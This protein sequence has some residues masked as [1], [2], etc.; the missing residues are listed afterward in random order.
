MS[1][2]S[3]ETL[4]LCIRQAVEYT[5]KSAGIPADTARHAGVSVS[6]KLN[7]LW[8]SNLIY[9]PRGRLHI[10]LRNKKIFELFSG[11]NH[12]QLAR[13]FNVSIQMIYQIVKKERLLYVRNQQ[14]DLF[15]T[16]YKVDKKQVTKYITAKLYV[17]AEIMEITAECLREI[18]DI[19][20]KR[21]MEL[22]EEVAKW[23]SL[24]MGGQSAYV[25]SAGN[26]G[27]STSQR[28]LF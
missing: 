6:A 5:L 22:G 27:I 20:V 13:N 12:A 18:P 10:M 8:A 28:E 7:D 23:V 15:S 25:K 21:A 19:S 3:H 17:L 11:D 24:H 1:I 2:A 14:A 9:I 26:A 16:P 4:I